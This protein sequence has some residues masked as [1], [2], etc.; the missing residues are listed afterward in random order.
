MNIQT[1]KL[2]IIN[3]LI[4][5]DDEKE[6]MRIETEILKSRSSLEIIYKP[7]SNDELLLRVKE[8]MEDYKKGNYTAQD[9]LE[10]ESEKW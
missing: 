6:L 1:R 3:Y 9:D 4:N 10:D 7:L 8:S 5:L 2:N